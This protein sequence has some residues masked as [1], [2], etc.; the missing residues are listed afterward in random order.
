MYL[1]LEKRK[2]ITFKVE[3]QKMKCNLK[4]YKFEKIEEKKDPSISISLDKQWTAFVKNYNLFV[5]SAKTG[6]EIQLTTDGSEKYSNAPSWDWYYLIDE[7]EPS[8]TNRMKNISVRWP[9]EASFNDESRLLILLEY[10]L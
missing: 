3:K 9:P 1:Q 6:E 10:L 2:A 8:N 5:K 4:S 7:S